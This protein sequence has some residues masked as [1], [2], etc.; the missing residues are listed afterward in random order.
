MRIMNYRPD[1][2]KR[3]ALSVEPHL[4][5]RQLRLLGDGQGVFEELYLCNKAALAASRGERVNVAAERQAYRAADPD[6]ECHSLSEC[7]PRLRALAGAISPGGVPV[8]VTGRLWLRTVIGD[9][10]RV[11]LAAEPERT[12]LKLDSHLFVSRAG[13]EFQLFTSGVRAEPGRVE[14]ETG[15]TVVRL[16]HGVTFPSLGALLTAG[17]AVQDLCAPVSVPVSLGRGG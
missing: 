13:S 2:I 8:S 17:W 6:G 9:V 15:D 3:L 14:S 1:E 5:A 10:A 11:L 16:Y 7:L 4:P 12:L